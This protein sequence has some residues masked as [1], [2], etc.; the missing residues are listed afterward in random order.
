LSI[1]IVHNDTLFCGYS[2]GNIVIWDLGSFT[3]LSTLKPIPVLPFPPPPPPP[4]YDTEPY[5]VVYDYLDDPE[6]IHAFTATSNDGIS[7][8][9]ISDNLLATSNWQNQINIFNFESTQP[10][11]VLIPFNNTQSTVRTTSYSSN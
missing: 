9:D 11:L 5:P 3:L 1:L 7:F 4:P 8:M 6:A 10:P 2:E